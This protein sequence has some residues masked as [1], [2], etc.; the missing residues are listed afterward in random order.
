MIP[1]RPAPRI[2]TF[3]LTFLSVPKP[4][5]VVVNDNDNSKNNRKANNRPNLIFMFW[6][7]S[8][9]YRGRTLERAVYR[10]YKPMWIETRDD[11]V[12]LVTI[13]FCQATEN[14]F[15]WIARIEIPGNFSGISVFRKVNLTPNSTIHT[16]WVTGNT[17]KSYQA[18]IDTETKVSFLLSWYII[19][20]AGRQL[21]SDIIIV[22]IK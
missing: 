4:S 2:R 15:T 5:D 13:H 3:V 12:K 18:V 1:N 6:Y 11:Q 17:D 7:D 21:S 22:Y 8:S 20:T 9:F 14:L 19:W 16:H 10:I